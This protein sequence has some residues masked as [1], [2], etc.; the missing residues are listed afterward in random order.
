MEDN[1]KKKKG[2]KRTFFNT[3]ILPYLHKLSSWI[4]EYRLMETFSDAEKNV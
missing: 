3:L 1:E 2:D 4:A